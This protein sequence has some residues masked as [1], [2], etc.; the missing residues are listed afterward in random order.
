MET[1]LVRGNKTVVSKVVDFRSHSF[2]TALAKCNLSGSDLPDNVTLSDGKPWD[3]KPSTG[4]GI[5]VYP[6]T[7]ETKYDMPYGLSFEANVVWSVTKGSAIRTTV[8]CQLDAA[9]ALD[10][11]RA[12]VLSGTNRAVKTLQAKYGSAEIE[13][14]PEQK[15][16]AHSYLTGDATADVSMLENL[17]AHNKVSAKAMAKRILDASKRYS[18]QLGDMLGR[19]QSAFEQLNAIHVDNKKYQTMILSILNAWDGTDQKVESNG[20]ANS[21]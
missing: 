16:Q 6:V 8:H 4:V 10:C 19:K 12:Y 14:W 17:A 1:V 18:S 9:D 11:A 3:F 7:R 21:D 5:Q 13:S 20:T 2:Y 15:S